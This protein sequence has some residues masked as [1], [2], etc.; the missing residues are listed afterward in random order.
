MSV[1]SVRR[2]TMTSS[3]LGEPIAARRASRGARVVP[4][5]RPYD[6]LPADARFR[7]DLPFRLDPSRRAHDEPG[8]A[9]DSARGRLCAAAPSS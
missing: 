1:A 8:D 3:N 2:S 6:A 9:G 4:R 5:A 7:A